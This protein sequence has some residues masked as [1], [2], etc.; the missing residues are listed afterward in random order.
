M[1]ETES[2]RRVGTRGRGY[3]WNAEGI[4]LDRDRG[5][6]ARHRGFA[7][8]L[9]QAAAHLNVEPPRRPRERNQDDDGGSAEVAEKAT[10]KSAPGRGRQCRGHPNNRGSHG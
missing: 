5:R 10:S 1:Q 9:G 3:R 6:R 2:A 7:I 8:E 4:A